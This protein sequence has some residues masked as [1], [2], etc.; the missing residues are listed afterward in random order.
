MRQDQA[1]D[2]R[3]HL[4]AA[5]ALAEVGVEGLWSR[6]FALGGTEPPARL[7]AYLDGGCEPDRSQYNVLVQALNE[8]F[9]AQDLGFPVPYWEGGRE[10]G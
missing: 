10:A 9:L 1:H 2:R 8:H 6:Y 7:R 4:V 5:M 3:R